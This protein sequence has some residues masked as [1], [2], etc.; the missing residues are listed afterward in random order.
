MTYPPCFKEA[1]TISQNHTQDRKQ[2][3]TGQNVSADEAT[4]TFFLRK[5]QPINIVEGVRSPPL[6]YNTTL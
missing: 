5:L 6:Q 4:L 3:K 2:D 1:D